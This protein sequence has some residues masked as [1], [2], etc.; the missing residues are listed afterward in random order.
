[1]KSGRVKCTASIQS[2]PGLFRFLFLLPLGRPTLR[3]L[4]SFRAWREI[5]CIDRRPLP[6]VVA[7]KRPAAII[8]STRLCVTPSNSAARWLWKDRRIGSDPLAGLSKLANGQ[9]DIRHARRELRPEEYAFLLDTTGKS[10]RAFRYLSGTDRRALYLAAAGTDLRASELASLMPAGFDLNATAPVVRVPAINTKNPKEAELPLTAEVAELLRD[11]L[12][13]RPLTTPIWPGT[14]SNSA[15]AK[16][17]RLD[18]KE[19]RKKWLPTFQD[20]RQRTAAEQSD[21]FLMR[22]R[23][24]RCRLPFVAALVHFPCRTIRRDAES[25]SRTGTAL[26][27]SLDPWSICPRCVARFVRSNECPARPSPAES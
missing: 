10:E 3:S 15:S 2:D 7:G 1:M 18:L 4:T 13:G 27:Y 24:L 26:R 16:M 8:A 12:A 9:T 14:W 5:M 25:R 6:N 21:S 22:R 23:G 17:I 19:A 20:A 11:Y